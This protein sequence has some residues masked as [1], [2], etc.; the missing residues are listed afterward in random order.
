MAHLPLNR[1]KQEELENPLSHTA[2]IKVSGEMKLEGL[3]KQ[4]E[5]LSASVSSL[6]DPFL[7][8]I[9]DFPWHLLTSQ[10]ESCRQEQNLVHTNSLG[11]IS[12]TDYSAKLIIFLCHAAAL[13]IGHRPK[14]SRGQT[15]P[16]GTMMVRHCA[17]PGDPMPTPRCVITKE[18]ISPLQRDRTTNYRATRA[19]N[20]HLKQPYTITQCHIPGVVCTSM[21]KRDEKKGPGQPNSELWLFT[22]G[23][24]GIAEQG[25]RV[26]CKTPLR[27]ELRGETAEL[28][29]P[30]K[31]LASSSSLSLSGARVH[32]QR[33]SSEVHRTNKMEGLMVVRK[34]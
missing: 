10:S 34:S 15:V 19:S 1:K 7:E 16:V 9:Q 13:S 20:C 6:F 8:G 17:A 28:N 18:T 27:L 29:L 2:S 32:P 14:N 21:A 23:L 26:W 11:L 3:E 12:V 5:S 4:E 30:A 31:S 25:G 24:T 33:M 22:I